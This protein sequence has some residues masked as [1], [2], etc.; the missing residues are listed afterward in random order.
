[1]AEVMKYDDLHELGTE[2][3]VKAAGKY[4][5][6]GKDYVVVDGDIL[7]AFFGKAHPNRLQ[8]WTSQCRKEKV[9]RQWLLLERWFQNIESHILRRQ[10]LPRNSQPS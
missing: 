2:A 7:C 4:V 9:T 10:S 1:M 5:Q 6:K 8:G 3:A